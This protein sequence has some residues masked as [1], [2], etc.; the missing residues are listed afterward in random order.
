MGFVKLAAIAIWLKWLN[1]RY[2]LGCA[3]RDKQ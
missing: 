2:G 3:W 1:R